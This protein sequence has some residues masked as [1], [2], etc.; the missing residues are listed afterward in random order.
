MASHQI[1]RRTLML[2]ALGAV[3]AGA[4]GVGTLAGCAGG[5]GGGGTGKSNSNAGVKFPTYTPFAGGPKPDLPGTPAGVLD[6]FLKY[7][8]DPA[9]V[10]DGAPGDGSAVSVFVQTYSPVAPGLASNK[11]WQAMNKALNADMQI[12]VVPANDYS[13]KFAAIVS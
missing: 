10:T 2:G 13:Q 9:K 3:G 1:D 6:A 7:P 12:S 11:Y 5:G 4:L 8:A